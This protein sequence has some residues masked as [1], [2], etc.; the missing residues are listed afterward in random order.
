VQLAD[1]LKW[2]IWFIEGFTATSF[3]GQVPDFVAATA[4]SRRHTH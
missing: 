2:F 4:D 1:P 3:A